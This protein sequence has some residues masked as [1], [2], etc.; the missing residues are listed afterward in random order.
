MM[1][2]CYLSLRRNT[3]SHI[4]CRKY[5]ISS[6]DLLE[7]YLIL[8]SNLLMHY[9]I[10]LYDFELYEPLSHLLGSEY[11]LHAY[12]PIHA[13]SIEVVASSVFVRN[14]KFCYIAIFSIYLHS[15]Q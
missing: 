13:L 5:A 9:M 12:D 10:A 7:V 4:K 15:C 1:I 2:S 11:F 8:S 3:S 14:D 6:D